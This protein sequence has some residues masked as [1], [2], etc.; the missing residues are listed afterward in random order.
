MTQL[1]PLK[2][3]F[4]LLTSPMRVTFIGFPPDGSVYESF[5]VNVLSALLFGS[6]MIV[7]AI[8]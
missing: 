8:P 5:N 6:A 4:D 7:T 2:S 1:L 3:K